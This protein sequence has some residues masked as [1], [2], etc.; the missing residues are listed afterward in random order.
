VRAL[1]L[2]VVAPDADVKALAREMLVKCLVDRPD[3]KTED[4]AGRRLKLDRQLLNDG[5][6]PQACD[7]F[8]R[9]IKAQPRTRAAEEARR[10]LADAEK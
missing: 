3:G 7:G 9:L 6:R 4:D 1:C 2:A 10:L 5:A 8:R